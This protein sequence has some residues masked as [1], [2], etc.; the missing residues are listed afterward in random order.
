MITLHWKNLR[1]YGRIARERLGCFLLGVRQLPQPVKPFGER[2]VVTLSLPNV[3]A[4]REYARAFPCSVDET[5]N[6][7]VD[8]WIFQRERSRDNRETPDTVLGTNGRIR[9]DR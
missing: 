7:I 2:L 3:E 6:V 1:Q 5:L 4:L 9:R 8:L